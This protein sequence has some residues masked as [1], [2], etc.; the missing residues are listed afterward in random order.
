M[1]SAKYSHSELVAKISVILAG[2]AGYSKAEIEIIEQAA[3]FHDVGKAGIL[4][5]ILNAPRALTA[6]EFEIVKKH[7]GIGSDMIMEAAQALY[8]AAIVAKHHHEWINDGSKGYIGLE[9]E[10]IHP[11]SRIISVS[12]VY[13]ALISK[14]VYKAAFDEKTVCEYMQSQSG[15][16]F[17]SDIVRLLLLHIDEISAIYIKEGRE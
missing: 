9:G 6:D 7:T 10:E 3:L 8:T 14:R 12:D 11:Y 1:D 4:K 17:D 15:K 16:Q 13:D 5:D 2:H